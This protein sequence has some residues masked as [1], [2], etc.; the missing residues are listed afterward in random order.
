[1]ET[2]LSLLI[3]V[4]ESENRIEEEESAD[5]IEEGNEKPSSAPKKKK[6]KSKKKK[7]GAAKQT[8]PPRTGI[9]KLFPSGKY[10]LGEIRDYKDE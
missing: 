6:K 1:L 3:K 10:P 2:K 7:A 8:S 5:E 9:S 4:N